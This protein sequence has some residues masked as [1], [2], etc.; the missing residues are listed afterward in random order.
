MTQPEPDL[1][2]AGAAAALAAAPAVSAR[3]LEVHVEGPDGRC[4]GCHSAVRLAP[5]WPCRLAACAM[6]ATA[7]RRGRAG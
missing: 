6:L 3:L 4:R 1:V 2:L 5:R 7:Q